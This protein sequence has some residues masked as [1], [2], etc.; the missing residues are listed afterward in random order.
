MEGGGERERER[1]R[2][3]ECV[4]V[5]GMLDDVFLTCLLGIWESTCRRC[6]RL[7]RPDWFG[8]KAW[9]GLVILSEGLRD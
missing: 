6:A 5:C 1:E 9:A 4:F 3:S 8:M 2:E 7:V